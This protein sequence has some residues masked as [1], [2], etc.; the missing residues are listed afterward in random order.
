M[1]YEVHHGRVHIIGAPM[2]LGQEKRGVDLGPTAI[3]YAGLVGRL[4]R[5]GWEV[6]DWGDISVAASEQMMR[7]VSFGGHPAYHAGA[8]INI[9]RG[10]HHHVEEHV[11]AEDKLIMLGGDHSASLGSVASSLQR[12]G[13]TGVI[14]I[15]AHGDF[16]TPATSPSG[17]VHGMVVAWLMGKGIPRPGVSETKLQADEICMIAIRDLDPLE[18][19]ALEESG[20][21]VAT[22]REVEERGISVVVHEALDLLGDVTSLHVSFDLDSLDPNVAPGVGTPVPGGLTHREALLLAEIL[23][24]DGRVCSLDLVEVN[25][26]LDVGNKTA[27]FAVNVAASM[28]GE[29]ILHPSNVTPQML[30]QE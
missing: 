10:L 15:D 12:P 28:L 20:I 1:N 27:D 30:E 23:G 17:N 11:R 13:K 26:M 14:W 9:A 29:R 18:A 5:Q 24:D 4:E 8:I 21:K 7:H 3:R 16:N 22:I 25:P 6:I 2:D 19:I